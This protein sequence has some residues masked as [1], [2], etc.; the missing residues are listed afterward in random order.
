MS[1][2]AVS[3]P[4]RSV[5]KRKERG[6]IEQ[7]AIKVCIVAAVVSV[8]TI[9]VADWIIGSAVDAAHSLLATSSI[10]GRQFWE[11][12]ERELDRAA[13]PSTDLPPEKKQKIINDLRVI[14]ARWRPFI[15]AMR[16]EGQK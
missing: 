16:D 6:A 1:D 8:C 9:F 13:D 2:T 4:G 10:G 3:E 7:F 11:R 12:I 15:D 14:A 5:S